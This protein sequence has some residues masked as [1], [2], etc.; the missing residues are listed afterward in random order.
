[1]EEAKKLVEDGVPV[2]PLPFRPSGKDN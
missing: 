1:L 2:L